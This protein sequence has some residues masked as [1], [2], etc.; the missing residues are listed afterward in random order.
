MFALW[1]T[2]AVV[3]PGAAQELK[4]AS[5]TY[6]Q[7]VMWLLPG[8]AQSLTLDASQAA[9][10]LPRRVG[11]GWRSFS[12]QCQQPDNDSGT[13]KG[14][15]VLQLSNAPVSGG[16]YV[17]PGKWVAQAALTLDIG[18]KDM[19]PSIQ[20]VLINYAGWAQLTWTPGSGSSGNLL[21]LFDGVRR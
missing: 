16:K 20:A 11:D 5:P 9:V 8:N 15:L 7:Q 21:T 18:G 10:T 2:L 13:P 4:L 3:V 12:F 6:D 19:L 14:S 17:A 1:A